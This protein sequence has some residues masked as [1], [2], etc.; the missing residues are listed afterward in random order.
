MTQVTEMSEV[1]GTI[2]Q[3]HVATH[4]TCQKKMDLRF[5]WSPHGSACFTAEASGGENS[6][7]CISVCWTKGITLFVHPYSFSFSTVGAHLCLAQSMKVKSCCCF[8]LVS[9]FVQVLI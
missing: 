8:I 3:K 7:Q 6:T 4:T 5:V 2:K 1:P 9:G